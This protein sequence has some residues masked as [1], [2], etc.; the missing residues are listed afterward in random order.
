MTQREK[1]LVGA[2][3]AAGVLWFGSQG[4]TRYRDA[5]DRNSALQLDAEQALVDAQTAEFRG[6]KARKQLNQ[7]TD[8]SLPTNREV[9]ESL[10]QDWLRSQLTGAGLEVTELADKS[11]NNRN[12]QFGEISVEARVTGT[13]AQVADFLHRF[14]SAPHLHRLSGATVIAADGG[15]KLNV[16]LTAGALILPGAG[17]TDR[18]S[19][20]EPRKLPKSM[21]AF[22]DGLVARNMFAAYTATAGGDAEGKDE[23]AAGAIFAWTDYGEYGWR[24][25]VKMKDAP[26]MKYYHQGDD[27]EIGK[28]NGKIVQLDGRRVVIE[29]AKGRVEVQFGRNFGEALPI[30]AP[31]A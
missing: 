25:G 7:W 26:D 15:Q 21:E 5:V 11:G 10:Y 13:L 6:Q 1:V 4:L 2:V 9:A 19:E 18:L 22:R 17:R 3:A 20:G 29:T 12:P 30:E 8:E 24:M 31:A 23:V 16:T 28:L 27:V 14:Y